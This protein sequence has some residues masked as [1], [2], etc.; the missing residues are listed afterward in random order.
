M[1][2]RVM[3]RVKRAARYK[4]SVPA[5]K[6]EGKCPAHPPPWPPERENK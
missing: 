6:E 2:L 5:R 4:K 3:Q 1:S